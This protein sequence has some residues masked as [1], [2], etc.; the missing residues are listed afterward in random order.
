[1]MLVVS[2]GRGVGVSDLRLELSRKLGRPLT[3]TLIRRLP[4]S[5]HLFLGA[6]ESGPSITSCVAHLTSLHNPTQP[7]TTLH[8]PTQPYTTPHYTMDLF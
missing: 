4:F 2:A 3:Y 5:L 6:W 1:M 7:Y 8:N